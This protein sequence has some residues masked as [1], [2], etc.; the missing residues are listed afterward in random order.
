MLGLHVTRGRWPSPLTLSLSPGRR[1]QCH[2]ITTIFQVVIECD[3]VSQVSSRLNI[4]TVPHLKAVKYYFKLF[5]R[6][7]SWNGNCNTTSG[8]SI[9]NRKGGESSSLIP[10]YLLMWNWIGVLEIPWVRK[11]LELISLPNAI[12]QGPHHRML[13]L[14]SDC[15]LTE[16][17]PSGAPQHQH[18]HTPDCCEAQVG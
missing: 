1:S 11:G 9:F 6:Q 14:L 4:S 16:N 17:P 7:K 3:K 13:S 12:T 8:P 18:T 5:L 2:L 10:S 15:I